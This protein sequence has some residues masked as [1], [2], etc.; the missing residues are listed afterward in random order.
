MAVSRI[1]QAKATNSLGTVLA[2]L[3]PLATRP[4]ETRQ[5]FRRKTVDSASH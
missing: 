5:S 1:E 2:N 4:S 3:P